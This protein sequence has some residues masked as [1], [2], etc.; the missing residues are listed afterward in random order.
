LKRIKK[1]KIVFTG[2]YAHL[3]GFLAFWWQ[4]SGNLNNTGNAGVSNVNCN[5]GLTN[6]NW[7]IA[8]QVT[9]DLFG[10]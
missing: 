5:N 9:D 4:A 6:A 2:I 8:A 1:K 10:S 3:R 7:N